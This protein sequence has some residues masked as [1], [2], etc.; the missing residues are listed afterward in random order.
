MGR[1]GLRIAVITLTV[2]STILGGGCHYGI[3]SLGPIGGNWVLQPVGALYPFLIVLI[4]YTTIE[5]GKLS[6]CM[7]F[8]VLYKLWVPVAHGG[9]LFYVLL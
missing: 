7:L 1:M 9:P 3:G 8:T 5:V 6:Y 2:Y 4:L